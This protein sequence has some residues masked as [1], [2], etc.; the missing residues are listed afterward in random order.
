MMIPATR[1]QNIDKLATKNTDRIEKVE[2]QC[3]W[4]IDAQSTTK[5]IS[6]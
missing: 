6:L 3:A 4:L 2:C 5:H 1:K